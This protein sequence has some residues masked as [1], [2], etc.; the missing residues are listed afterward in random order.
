M[1][2]TVNE[3]EFRNAFHQMG[4]GNQFSYEGLNLI[5]EYL[6]ELD[7]QME[8]DVIAICCDFEEAHYS[9]VIG[10]YDTEITENLSE[11]ATEEEQIEYIENWLFYNTNVLGKLDDGTFVFQQF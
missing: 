11:D 6:E 1:I 7:P 3:Y 5:F 8:L 10:R 2:Q 4:R 9:D